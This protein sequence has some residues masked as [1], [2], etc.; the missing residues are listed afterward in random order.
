MSDHPSA[1]LSTH[2]LTPA[3][4]NLIAKFKPFKI[5]FSEGDLRQQREYFMRRTDLEWISKIQ[6]LREPSLE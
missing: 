3:G 5:A 2:F 6:I 1:A 4:V